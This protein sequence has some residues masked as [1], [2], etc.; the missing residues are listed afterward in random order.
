MEPSGP[1]KTEKRRCLECGEPISGRVDKKFCSDYCRNAYHNER[2]RDTNNLV[3]NINHI[4][5]KNRRILAQCNP[6][7]KTTVHRDKLVNAGFNFHYHT[8]TYTTRAGA[9]Y[10][11]CYEEGYLPLENDFFTLVRRES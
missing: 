4:L 3:R 10:Y 7:G 11:F 1:Q 6:A 2:N 5:R 8:H 9:V